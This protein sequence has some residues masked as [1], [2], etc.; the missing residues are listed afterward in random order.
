MD[1]DK[2]MEYMVVTGQVDDTFGLIETC[3]KC[4][5]PLEKCN[6]SAFP[7]YCPN[8]ELFINKLKI[9]GSKKTKRK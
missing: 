8:C 6:D 4:G 1:L 5:K 3:P 7:Y 9:E 2:F